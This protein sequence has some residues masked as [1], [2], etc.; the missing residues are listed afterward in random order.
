MV[1]H[2]SPQITLSQSDCCT[3]TYCKD[4]ETFPAVKENIHPFNFIQ[5]IYVGVML[6]HDPLTHTVQFIFF[7]NRTCQLYHIPQSFLSSW[8]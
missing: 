3:Q 1:R 5:F 4:N 8:A 7:F 6:Q 2:A